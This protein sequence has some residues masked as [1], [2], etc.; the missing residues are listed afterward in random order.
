MRPTEDLGS[1]DLYLRAFSLYRT[2]ARADLKAALVLLDRAIALDPDNGPAL[3]LAAFCR[4]FLVSIWSDDA[5]GQLSQARVLVSRALKVGADDPEV[6]ANLVFATGFDGDRETALSLADRALQLN[7]GS[8][9]AWIASGFARSTFGEPGLGFDQLEMGL[10]LD[11]LASLRPNVLA[12]QGLARCAEGRLGDG[13]ALLKQAV[14]LRPEFPM[15]YAFLA[16]SQGH[17]G[18]LVAG[19]ESV[20]RFE[21]ITPIGI[22]VFAKAH[23]DPEARK[24]LLE[25]LDLVDSAKA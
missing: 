9:Y 19:R 22:R 13:V 1:Y 7:P 21:S 10:R 6:L 12:M 5:A 17:L 4:V 20:A 23:P 15:A 25:G 18:D 11:P 24:L 2:L 16:A 14:Q 3:G 8:S